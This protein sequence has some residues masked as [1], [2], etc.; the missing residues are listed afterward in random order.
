MS[1]SVNMERLIQNLDNRLE[2]NSLDGYNNKTYLPLNE[3]KNNIPDANFSFIDK[4]QPQVQLKLIKQPEVKIVKE[5]INYFSTC[6]RY[7]L[8]FFIFIILSHQEFD[9]ITNIDNMTNLYRIV[10]KAVVF[11][12]I[13]M[14]VNIF[15]E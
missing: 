5:K 3:N 2:N 8:I 7:L 9:Y 4:T 13:L 14:I 1:K 11:V 6:K 10:L 12:I 15:I